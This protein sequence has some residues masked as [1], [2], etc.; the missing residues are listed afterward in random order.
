MTTVEQIN[1]SE[2]DVIDTYSAVFSRLSFPYKIELMERLI[3]SLKNEHEIMPSGEFIP[4]KSSEQIIA[5]LRESRSSGK[6]RII[7]PF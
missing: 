4:E 7:E 3:K 2:R 1:Y 6:T 5:E